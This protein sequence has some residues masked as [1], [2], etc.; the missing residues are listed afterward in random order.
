MIRYRKAK[1]SSR[2]N[3]EKWLN[4]PYVKEPARHNKF[5][6][7]LQLEPDKGYEVKVGSVLKSD[8]STQ[9]SAI[10]TAKTGQA[11]SPYITAMKTE[12]AGNV[13]FL[14]WRKPVD[15]RNQPMA[16]TYY[17]AAS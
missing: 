9:W 11:G 4:G 12:G 16:V 1:S 3:E 10:A 15:R 17:K 7:T 14:E 8:G 5:Q 2:A 13:V 6:K